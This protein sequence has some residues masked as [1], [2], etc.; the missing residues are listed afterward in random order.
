MLCSIVISSP[1]PKCKMH[2]TSLKQKK[3]HLYCRQLFIHILL[4]S[5][6]F[7]SFWSPRSNLWHFNDLQWTFKKSNLLNGLFILRSCSPDDDELAHKHYY[8]S[9][10]KET[11]ERIAYLHV[12]VIVYM[13]WEGCLHTSCIEKK[14][15]FFVHVNQWT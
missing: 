6:R 13:I 9:T 5:A 7:L 14:M 10:L 3:N 15:T 12:H 1:K 2:S 11:S 4:H 8:F